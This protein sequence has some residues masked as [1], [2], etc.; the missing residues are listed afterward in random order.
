MNPDRLGRYRLGARIATGGMA[1]LFLAQQ[2]GP[3]GFSK[4]VVI[5]RLLP[6]LARNRGVVVADVRAHE[7]VVPYRHGR[8]QAPLLRHVGEASIE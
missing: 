6:H 2:Q 3:E 8:K 4:T 5:K 1:E 7:N